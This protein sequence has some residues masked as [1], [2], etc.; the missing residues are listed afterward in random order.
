MINKKNEDSAEFRIKF[1]ERIKDKKIR[2]ISERV[3]DENSGEVVDTIIG[4]DGYFYVNKNNELEIY[5]SGAGKSLF[6]A[7]IPDLKAYE[8]LSLEGVVL[9][10]LDLISGK[11]RQII[12]YYKYYR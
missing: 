2:Y 10:S 8:F 7:Y 1:V 5:L 11:Q 4:K 12:A 3:K 9:E 6:R